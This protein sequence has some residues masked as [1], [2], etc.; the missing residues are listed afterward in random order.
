MLHETQKTINVD[1]NSKNE[2][3]TY[4]HRS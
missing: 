1:K 4:G 2:D 3:L